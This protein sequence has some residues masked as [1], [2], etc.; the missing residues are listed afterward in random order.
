MSERKSSGMKLSR[1]NFGKGVLAAGSAGLIYG[2]ARAPAIAQARRDLRVGVFGG[3]F[4]ITGDGGVRCGVLRRIE[5]GGT[6]NFWS[7]S[8]K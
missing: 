7:E 6:E 3:D 8:H 5:P 4:G 1:R 2:T